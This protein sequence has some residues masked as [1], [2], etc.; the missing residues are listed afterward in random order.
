M[1]QW[2]QQEW[3]IIFF[4]I[5]IP[6][7]LMTSVGAHGRTDGRTDRES[8]IIQTKGLVSFTRFLSWLVFSFELCTSRRIPRIS[9]CACVTRSYWTCLGTNILGMPLSEVANTSKPAGKPGWS[10]LNCASIVFGIDWPSSWVPIQL[11][12]G[13]TDILFMLF[14][15]L[16]Y[17]SIAL[18]G[19]W[20]FRCLDT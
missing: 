9:R 17:I 2:R 10:P 19:T 1:N 12:I 20:H 5:L 14:A 16:W 6:S 8:R 7:K 11:T 4:S 13:S 3:G 15:T 18:S